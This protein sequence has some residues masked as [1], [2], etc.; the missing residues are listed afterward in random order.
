MEEE[1]FTKESVENAKVRGMVI[2]LLI[3]VALV[4]VIVGVGFA[5]SHFQNKNNLIGE[6][7]NK[8]INEMVKIIDKSFYK[9]SD[10]VSTDNITEGI[11]KGIVESLNDPYAEYYS[12]EELKA[13]MD[14]Y[15]GISYGIGCYVA[16]DTETDMP[17]ISGVFE[18][19]PAEEVGIIEGDIIYEVDGV[20][21]MGLSLS[22]VVDLIKGPENSMVHIK[23][24][25]ED[26]FVEFD[27]KRGKLIETTSVDAGILIED[28]E[29]GYIRI[30][31]FDENTI[32]QFNE[33]MVDL[34]AENIKGLILDLRYNPGGNLNACV[35]VARRIL[36][37]GIIVYTE[38][39]KGK[40]TNYTCDG[41]NKIDMPL[42]VL[43]NG[44]SASA[45]EILSGA[46]QDYGI[47][48]LIGTTTFG[49][50]IVQGFFDMND[51][52]AIKLTTSAYYTPSGKNIQGI[53]I[54][55]DIVIEY[56]KELAEKSG[57]DNQ[58]TKAIEV[59]R[60]K[61]GQ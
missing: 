55:P 59:L 13:E 54:E 56:D 30:K 20:S 11:Y 43:I 9:Y 53:G 16:L 15:E 37:E 34:R 23:M 2:G 19:S 48:T 25:R 52:S 33:A 61:I 50:G 3:G 5:V 14:D 46:I 44:Y 4:G 24:F 26:D 38:N 60:E 21:T 1:I 10:D 22:Q 39:V 35:E 32:D 31:E 49:K 7:E 47:G 8:K 51:G 18:Q 27:V 42:V 12:A 36:P 58:I 17:I 6:K 41:K 45:S 57:E 29:I 28:E 40:R